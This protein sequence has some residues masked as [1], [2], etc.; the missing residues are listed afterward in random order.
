MQGMKPFVLILALSTA[1]FA[2]APLESWQRQPLD[3][4]LLDSLSPQV[5]IVPSGYKFPSSTSSSI[6]A[7]VNMRK[8]IIV[9]ETLPNL[10]EA[11]YGFPSNRIAFPQDLPQGR[12]DLIAN[13][14]IGSI[15]ALKKK[16]E[17]QFALTIRKEKRDSLVYS[18]KADHA[19]APG[20]KAVGRVGNSTLSSESSGLTGKR[21]PL[22]NLA[23]YLESQVDAP[24]VDETEYIGC[25]DL[26]L[27]WEQDYSDKLRPIQEALIQQLGLKLEATQRPLEFLVVEKAP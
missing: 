12:Y 2:Q 14:P 5:Q 6:G 1:A 20:L 22:S 11:L 10:I 7:D 16:I 19:G 25:F 27:R 9:G 15:D 18:L 4:K 26:H 17:E 8:V 21:V 23:T 13:L 24:V 3:A